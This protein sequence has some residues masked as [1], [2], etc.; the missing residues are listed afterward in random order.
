LIDPPVPMMGQASNC[1]HESNEA[2]LYLI[3]YATRDI[4]IYFIDIK[5]LQFQDCFVAALLA[6][7]YRL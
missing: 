5:K 1:H 6:M 4:K 2:I 7:T 3:P